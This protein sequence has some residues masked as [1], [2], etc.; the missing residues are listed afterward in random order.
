MIRMIQ[1]SSPGHAKAYFSDALSKSDYYTSDQELAGY[2]QGRLADRLG[3][4]GATGRDDFFAF[5]ENL[6]PHTGK[7][8][9]PR[10]KEERTTGYDINFHCPKSV[11]VLHVFSGDDHILKAFQESVTATMLLVE[12]D[13]KTRVR[14]EGIYDDRSTGELVWANFI[15]Q[16][17][18]PVEGYLPDPH[19]HSHCFVFNATW[20]ATEQRIKAAQFRLSLIHI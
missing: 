16:T 18:R 20:D 2:W 17:A 1:S 13:S 10:T 11:S 9:T 5:C 12:A 4:K 7:P 19:L 3:I 15:H 14:Q 6:H 8:L